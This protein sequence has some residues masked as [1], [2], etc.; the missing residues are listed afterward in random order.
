MAT[1]IRRSKR[2]GRSGGIGKETPEGSILAP[3]PYTPIDLQ[4]AATIR[5]QSRHNALQKIPSTSK[6][7]LKKAKRILWASQKNP[8]RKNSF[9]KSMTTSKKSNF[10][11]NI[12]RI[13]KNLEESRRI[14]QNLKESQ[15]I[16]KNFLEKS[17]KTSKKLNFTTNIQAILH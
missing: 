1:R 4:W 17:M 14:L 10:T 5:P 7:I 2:A 8:L 6:R 13:S 11:T 15:R 3:P 16:P 12:Q 9:E